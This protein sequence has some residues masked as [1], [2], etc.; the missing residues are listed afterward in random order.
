MNYHEVGDM[1]LRKLRYEQILDTIRGFTQYGK[2][3]GLK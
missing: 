1:K 2:E 3:K